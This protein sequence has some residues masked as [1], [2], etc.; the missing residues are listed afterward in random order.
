VPE[1][2]R[3]RVG[4]GDHVNEEAGQVST[5]VEALIELR[6]RTLDAYIDGQIGEDES[7]ADLNAIAIEIDRILSP[8]RQDDV[9]ER[10]ARVVG[11]ILADSHAR[12]AAVP[13]AKAA[14]IEFWHRRRLERLRSEESGADGA[15]ARRESEL[16]ETEPDEV[17]MGRPVLAALRDERAVHG[18]LERLRVMADRPVPPPSPR[19]LPAFPDVTWTD[20]D[21]LSWEESSGGVPCQGCG[22]PFL[23][24]ETSQR[25]GESW[26]AYRERMAPIEAEFRAR[27][28]EHGTSWTVGGG[29]AHCRRCCAPHPLSPDQIR[30]LNQIASPPN[31]PAPAPAPEVR[32]RRCGTCHKPLDPDHVCQL[33]DL[34]KRLRAVVEAVL[35][36]ELERPG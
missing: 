7:R 24:D 18:A 22:R 14:R 27:H 5:S 16:E 12:Q 4:A 20:D 9:D 30:R 23:G 17:R 25:E 21:R 34:P 33:E 10:A 8:G 19:Q 15:G 28:P 2:R 26:A 31:P 35:A 1:G 13:P 6:N 32:V 3:A 11:A 29:S 36:K